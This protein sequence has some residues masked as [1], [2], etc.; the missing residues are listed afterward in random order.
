MTTVLSVV[1]LSSL[2]QQPAGEAI[3]NQTSTITRFEKARVEY[4]N[5]RFAQSEALYLS[6]LSTLKSGDESGR[7]QMLT[8]LGD[9]YVNTDELTKAE[10]A[11]SEALAIYQ[12]LSNKRRSA[13]L[14]RD[15]GAVYSLEH[16]SDEALSLL[17]R[18]LKEANQVPQPDPVLTEH[19]LNSLG[20]E[21]FRR[22]NLQKAEQFLNQAMKT[23][24]DG[25]GHYETADTLNNLAAIYHARRQYSKA[26][27]Y[28]SRAFKITEQQIGPAHPD[29]SFMLSSMAMLYSNTRQYDKAEQ[30]YVRALKIVEGNPVFET[31]TARLLQ[32]LSRNY[33]AAGR[34]SESEAA[35]FKAAEIA[36]RHL[37]QHSDMADILNAYASTLTKG[38]RK[39]EAEE[40]RAEVRR[41]RITE[42][43]VI[44]A[45]SSSPF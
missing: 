17:Q 35:L 4:S 24:P 25:D 9:V 19:I 38:G 22:G 36:R 37:S 1:L 39:Q 40:L 12:K 20:M 26:E 18:A 43:M 21:Y 41:A 30:Y 11:Y 32:G 5:G 29:M 6:A 15:L 45:H 2:L 3:A 31:R 34:T 23:L 13:L 33:A 7:A 28:L 42:D 16:R 27:E 14:L 10:R 44:K 8:E